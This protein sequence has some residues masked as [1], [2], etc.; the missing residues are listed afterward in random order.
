MEGVFQAAWRGY[1]A[2]TAYLDLQARLEAERIERHSAV[3]AALETLTH[4]LPVFRARVK[5]LQMRW[6]GL[7]CSCWRRMLCGTVDSN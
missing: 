6:A 1:Y 3:A 4:W 7:R 2:R 5:L